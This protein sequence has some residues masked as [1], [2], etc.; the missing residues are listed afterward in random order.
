MKKNYISF[1]EIENIHKI[2]YSNNLTMDERAKRI[3]D[4]ISYNDFMEIWNGYVYSIPNVDERI[5]DLMLT[6]HALFVLYDAW[7]LFKPYEKANKKLVLEN[8]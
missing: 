7:G 1:D 3:H 6:V 5:K 2:A 4:I 8:K